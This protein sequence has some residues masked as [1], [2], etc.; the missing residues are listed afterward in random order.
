M[1]IIRKFAII[2]TRLLYFFSFLKLTIYIE[3]ITYFR[4]LMVIVFVAGVLLLPGVSVFTSVG[5]F[6]I[7][8][9]TVTVGATGSS[10]LGTSGIAANATQ[11][12]FE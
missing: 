10:I 11:V 7:T 6:V 8:G 5:S 4:T 2:T 12:T 9:A 3:Y 1:A